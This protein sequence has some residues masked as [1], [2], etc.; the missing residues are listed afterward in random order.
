M[1]RQDGTT[2]CDSRW[3]MRLISTVVAMVVTSGCAQGVPLKTEVSVQ[4]SPMLRLSWATATR[5]S[6]GILVRGQV[7][8][9]HCC[10]RHLSGHIH[11]K[12]IGE[13]GATLATADVPWGEF[14]ARQLHS[15]S[16]KALL[17]L[18]TP[19]TGAVVDIEFSTSDTKE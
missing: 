11:L 15:A 2:G 12:A 6:R 3:L 8:Q 19:G 7:Q 16:F 14:I 9:V 18:A 5:T 1:L 17:P 10:S 13:N 4:R